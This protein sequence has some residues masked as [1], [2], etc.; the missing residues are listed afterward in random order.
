MQV[1]AIV[2]VYTLP[3]IVHS[4]ATYLIRDL[5]NQVNFPVASVWYVIFRVA[6]RLFGASAGGGAVFMIGVVATVCL[7]LSSVAG[8]W[9]FVVVEIQKRRRGDS[10]L[11]FD[12][13]TKQLP[14]TALL[15]TLA[16]AVFIC[17]YLTAQ[18]SA[19][20]SNL[21]IDKILGSLILSAWGAG[22]LWVA[23]GDIRKFLGN[24]ARISSLAQQG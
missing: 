17:A 11:R 16:F 7:V 9:Y 10:A 20:M 3:K 23:I 2:V 24:K 4:Y 5:V 18:H 12:T 15:I 14:I 8:F 22:L 1:I 21:K 6:D 19:D 13:L